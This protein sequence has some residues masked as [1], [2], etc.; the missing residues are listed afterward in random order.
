MVHNERLTCL[1]GWSASSSST[2]VREVARPSKDLANKLCTFVGITQIVVDII[3]ID[4]VPLL[5]LSLPISS[6]VH[7]FLLSVVAQRRW[8]LTCNIRLQKQIA[9]LHIILKLSN[10]F[11]FFL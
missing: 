3:V 6:Q 2:R 5:A 1:G 10:L 4:P 7:Q 9:H 8:R 11:L